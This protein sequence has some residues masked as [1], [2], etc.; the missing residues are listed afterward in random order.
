MGARASLLRGAG[1]LAAPS[2]ASTPVS[3]CH[4][5]ES[6]GLEGAAGASTARVTD[7]GLGGACQR[8]ALVAVAGK[9]EPGRVPQSEG[10]CPSDAGRA[11]SMRIPSLTTSQL[12]SVRVRTGPQECHRRCHHLASR[13][14]VLLRLHAGR[15]ES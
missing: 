11:S 7:R 15:R 4:P 1:D 9:H 14:V 2:A 5:R 12:E 8:G 6:R 10:V 13:S 3:R